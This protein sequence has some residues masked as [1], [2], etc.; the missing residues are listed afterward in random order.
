MKYKVGDWVKVRE[1]LEKNKY[2]KCRF[3][4]DMEQYK[5]K[6]FQIESSHSNWGDYYILR[7]ADTW[8]WSEE[9]L[10]PAKLA[11]HT[12]TKEQFKHV[13]EVFDKKGWHWAGGLKPL[14]R[15]DSFEYKEETC[16]RYEDNFGYACKYYYEEKGYKVISYSEFLE[17][18]GIIPFMR[19]YIDKGITY[20]DIRKAVDLVKEENKMA[21]I[22]EPI[23]LEECAKKNL[24]EAKAK[25]E[26][27]RKNAEIEYAANEYRKMIDNLDRLKR[28]KKRIDED[29]KEQEA[30]LKVFGKK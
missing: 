27:E 9:M 24:A 4:Q 25:I 26:E 19:E 14:E 7:N 29:I 6:I 8:A 16:I 15:L 20:D 23:K 17:M 30:E 28:N 11:I 5:G 18:E 2:D 10:E 3:T 13:M 1:D 22:E 12:P 21:Y